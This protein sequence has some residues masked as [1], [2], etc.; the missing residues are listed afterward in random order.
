MSKKIQTTKKP[1]YESL[2]KKF[3]K[4]CNFFNRKSKNYVRQIKGLQVNF[5]HNPQ[6]ILEVLP[7][8]KITLKDKNSKLK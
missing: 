2:I 4:N 5:P 8:E 6:E 1:Q 7:Q 3:K